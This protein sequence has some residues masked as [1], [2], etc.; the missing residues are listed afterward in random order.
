MDYTGQLLIAHPKL[1]GTFFER[2]VI[3]VYEHSE[4][5]GT[6]GLVLNKPAK[7]PVKELFAQKGYSVDFVDPIRRGGP[8]NEKAVLM[9][10][11]SEWYSSNTIMSNE[12]SIS[13][14]NFMIE[15]MSTGNMP[16]N[17]KIFIGISGWAPGQLQS[18]IDG[19]P[20]YRLE[21]RWLTAKATPEIVFDYDGD[22]QWNRAIEL[23]SQEMIDYYF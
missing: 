14:D 13:S 10:H 4:L 19:T 2:S 9:L 11:S 18:E 15:K 20:P 3:Y 17:W 12:F 16:D 6:S 8:I 21:N 7:H 5:G 1:R 23:S 22:E